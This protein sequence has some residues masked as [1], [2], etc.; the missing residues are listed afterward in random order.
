MITMDLIGRI[1]RM[2]SRDKNSAREISRVTGLSRNT[3]AKWVKETV[4]VQASAVYRRPSVPRKLAPYV[5]SVKQALQSD[6]FRAKKYRR[7]ARALYKQIRAAGYEGGYSRLTDFVREWREQQGQAAAGKAFVPLRFEIG[8]AFQFDWSE[9]GLVIGGLYRKLQL[10]HMKLCFSRAFW[11]VA[12][13]SQGHEMLFDAHTRGFAGLG[14]V[15]RRGIYD[16]MKTAVDQVPRSKGHRGKERVVNARFA[17]MCAHYLFDADFCNVAS[18]WE[19]GVVEKNVQDSRRR[20]W[21]EASSRR[22]S[23]LA[24][25]NAWL[26]TRCCELWL[27]IKHP[28]HRDFSVAEMLEHERERLMPMPAPFDGYVEEMARVSSTCLVSVARN[29]YSVPCELVGQM[30][31]TRLYPGRVKVVAGSAVVADHERL[32][33]KS[34]TVYDW[35]HYIPLLQ[36]K[37]GA[38]RNGA[39]FADLPEPLQ[40][41]RRSL[42]RQVGGDRLMAKVLALVPEAGLEAVLVA[43]ELALEG[44]PPSGRVSQEHVIN[45]LARLNSPARPANVTTLLQVMTPP[46]ADTARYD[47]LRQHEEITHDDE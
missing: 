38:L 47:R 4:D 11:L 28:E 32:K 35:Q 29:R 34:K 10:A 16:N 26:G 19:K 46:I 21:I 41:L 40:R 43:V 36:R 42:L 13:P 44:A 27:E 18:G 8:E 23:S 33:D 45:V 12:Y 24:E 2:Y 39:P 20:V 30:V 5:D 7:T 3:V 37:P 31:S 6:A 17:N 14:G 22:W 9:E 15:A 1:R 25:L